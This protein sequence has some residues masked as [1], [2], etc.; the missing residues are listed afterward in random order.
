MAMRRLGLC[1]SRLH[2]PLQKHQGCC[3]PVSIAFVKSAATA[4][5]RSPRPQ[6]RGIGLAPPKISPTPVPEQPFVA[7]KMSKLELLAEATQA[8][9]MAGTGRDYWITELRHREMALV[10]QVEA[11]YPRIVEGWRTK[12]TR[13]VKQPF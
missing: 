8:H 1:M 3:A 11:A 2:G 5:R 10:E 9:G 13:L 4:L 7:M 12:P 6:D